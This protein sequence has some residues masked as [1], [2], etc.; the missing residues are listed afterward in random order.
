MTTP[1]QNDH[2]F[3]MGREIQLYLRVGSSTLRARF[4]N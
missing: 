1:E 3:A 4:P 2:G